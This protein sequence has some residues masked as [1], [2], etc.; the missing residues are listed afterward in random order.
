MTRISRTSEITPQPGR[1]ARTTRPTRL[2]NPFAPFCASRFR[3]PARRSLSLASPSPPS[4]KGSAAII[5]VGTLI[6]FRCRV[7]V[8]LEGFLPFGHQVQPL[9]RPQPCPED[10][11]RC[12]RTALPKLCSHELSHTL[13]RGPEFSGA[14]PHG[15]FRASASPSSSTRQCEI[16]RD[17]QTYSLRWPVIPKTLA[18]AIKR[19]GPGR[20][21]SYTWAVG[22]YLNAGNGAR[23]SGSSAS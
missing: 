2:A 6:P 22:V 20:V 11:W 1:L 23:P 10:V 15:S 7:R 18:S 3:Y 21:S 17:Q 5:G 16:P 9:R 14:Y 19:A 13:R 12:A 8:C 4:L